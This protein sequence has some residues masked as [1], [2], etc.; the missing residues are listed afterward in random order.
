MEGVR[1]LFSSD[2]KHEPEDTMT[3]KVEKALEVKILSNG[4]KY[5]PGNAPPWKLPRPCDN[6]VARNLDRTA[7]YKDM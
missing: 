7:I 6:N 5:E 1:I 2:I 3:E 4:I